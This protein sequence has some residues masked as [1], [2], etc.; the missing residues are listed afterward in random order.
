MLKS[1]FNSLA[2]LM[3]STIVGSNGDVSSKRILAFFTTTILASS[4]H[5]VFIICFMKECS[6][7]MIPYLI[8]ILEIDFGFAI[9]VLV[10]T[11]AENITSLVKAFRGEKSNGTEETK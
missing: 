4:M 7:A 8:R 6:I 9:L 3:R 10:F 5:V 1:I 2:R 11:T